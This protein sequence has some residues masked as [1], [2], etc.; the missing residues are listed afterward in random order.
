MAIT[1]HFASASAPALSPDDI[2]NLQLQLALEGIEVTP[3]IPVENLI[4]V[5]HPHLGVTTF[6]SWST[7]QEHLNE[8]WANTYW[9]PRVNTL[10]SYNGGE[11]AHR[12]TN[13]SGGGVPLSH[14]PK[15]P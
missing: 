15:R 4:R 7:I 8:H 6:D 9:G 2:L 13:P 14:R 3:K 12:R 10:A 5:D 11:H 1:V